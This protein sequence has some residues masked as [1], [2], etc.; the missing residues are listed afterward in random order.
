MAAKSL[1]PGFGSAYTSEALTTTQTGADTL[2]AS[3]CAS[4]ALQV[5]GSSATGTVDLQQ[6]FVSGKWSTLISQMAVTDAG[7]FALPVT[8]GPFG[9]L[10]LNATVTGGT[11]TFTIVGFPMPRMS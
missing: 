3:R 8:Q 4:I 2:D 6:S 5:S 11:C 7:V 10:R 9:V 1:L